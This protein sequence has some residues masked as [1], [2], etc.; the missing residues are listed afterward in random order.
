MLGG[1]LTGAM[2][3]LLADVQKKVRQV[4]ENTGQIKSTWAF[5]ETIHCTIS[6]FVSTSFKTQPTNESYREEYEKIK[7]IKMKSA[8][9]LP[10]DVRVTNIRNEK[11]GEV[12]YREHQLAGQPA[13]NY[14]TQGSAAL[15]DPFGGVIQYDT[16]LVRA[17]DQSD[18]SV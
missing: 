16:L 11:T 15:L 2:Y 5:K 9:P 18:S 7:Y 8:E 1:C 6:P 17:S 13:T 4:D 3:P 10:E 12:I 14:N